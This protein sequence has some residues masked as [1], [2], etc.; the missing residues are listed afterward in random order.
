MC[1]S[2][3]SNGLIQNYEKLSK[4]NTEKKMG[5]GMKIKPKSLVF[6]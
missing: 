4:L 6:R 2:T 5:K 3:I 1:K